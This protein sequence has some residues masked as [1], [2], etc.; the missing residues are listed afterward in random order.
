M[1]DA[2]AKACDNA[3]KMHVKGT[4]ERLQKEPTGARERLLAICVAMCWQHHR[5]HPNELLVLNCVENVWPQKMNVTAS[6]AAEQL[7]DRNQV[8]EGIELRS[9]TIW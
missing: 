5:T 9:K 6:A 7:A 8:V 1:S 4:T 2:Q 3:G